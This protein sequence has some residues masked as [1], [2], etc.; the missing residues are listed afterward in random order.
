MSTLGS[1]T[2]RLIG[3]NS[4]FNKTIAQTQKQLNASTKGLQTIAKSMTTVGDSM[5]KGITV[6]LIAIGA[7]LLK[8]GKDFDDAYD[9][10]RVGTGKTGKE[11]KGLQKDFKEVAKV[12]A[13]SFADISTA[14]TGYSQKLGL[15]GKPLQ[16]LSTQ[17]LNLS[18]LTKTDLNVNIDTSAKLFNNWKIST[19]NQSKTLDLLYRAS[20]QTGIGIDK[21]MGSVAESGTIL[22]GMGYSLETSI[23][24]VAQFDKEG[25]NLGTT[26]AGMKKA[27]VTMAKEGFTDPQEVLAVYVEKIKG[28]KDNIE[29]TG[30]AAELFGARGGA[31]MAIAIREGRLNLDELVESLKTGKD[32]INDAAN[33]TDDWKEKLILLKN[34]ISIAL[35]PLAT[36]VFDA[37]G[38]AVEGVTPKIEALAKWFGNLTPE[39]QDSIIQ[40]SAIIA[41]IPIF[42]SGIGRAA[43]GIIKFRNAVLTMNAGLASF[44]IGGSGMAKVLVTIADSVQ[45]F[46]AQGIPAFEL[47]FEQIGLFKSAAGELQHIVHQMTG[48]K[49]QNWFWIPGKEGA[50]ANQEIM[51]MTDNIQNLA[52]TISTQSPEAQAKAMALF[53]SYKEGTITLKEFE[54]GLA[55]VSWH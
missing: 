23:A 20:Q 50:A 43:T 17:V 9:K 2:I 33:A 36:K 19:E 39:M 35:E 42:I 55:G 38:R 52:M 44:A 3:D 21:L 13:S 34:N 53:T 7:G 12:A 37:I 6:P 41:I 26:L 4:Q 29:A 25:L 5:V 16:T 18:R 31:A 24:L 10:I 48:V 11:F 45:K 1:L 47:F 14:I 46:G 30:I 40:W 15:S 51:D 28:A 32:S 8:I 54:K 27:L 49:L 22:R